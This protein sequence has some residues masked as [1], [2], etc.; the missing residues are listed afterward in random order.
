M[1]IFINIVFLFISL[2]A[3]AQD[4][5]PGDFVESA[6][7]SYKPNVILYADLGYNAAPASIRYDF[8]Q[9]IDKIKLRHNFK[10]MIGFGFSYK[11][12]SIRLGAALVGNVRPISR[13]GK[14]N[15]V[16]L[17][18]NFSIKKTY[19]EIDFRTYSGYV[20]KDAKDWDSTFNAIR[21]ND[22]GQD[23]RTFNFALSMWYFDNVK[24]RIDPFLGVK[25]QYK[26]PV[27]T[28]FLEGKLDVFGIGNNLG[29][30]IPAQLYDT[31][32]TKTRAVSYSAVDFGVIPG[33]GHVNNVKNWQYGMMLA[34]GPMIQFK[35]Y[36]VDGVATSLAG[37]VGR[38]DVRLIAGYTVPQ[39]FAMFSLELDNKSITFAQL[40]YKQSFYRMRLSLGYRFKTKEQRK[41]SK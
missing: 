27:T 41:A 12:F 34:L 13:Y 14:A 19:S 15:Y 24:F 40:K 35:G 17:G 4:S 9:G 28:W 6:Y 26:R 5:I 39:F 11:W 30:I 33:I 18:I 7:I 21:P 23:I 2:C 36:N 3:S 31:T 16:D 22:V 37:I 8:G 25:G 38:Y 10:T 32:N 29:S 20:L 1:K